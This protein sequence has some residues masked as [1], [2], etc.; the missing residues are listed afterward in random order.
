MRTNGITISEPKFSEFQEIWF[1]VVCNGNNGSLSFAEEV[2]GA[3]KE[4]CLK[5]ANELVCRVFE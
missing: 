2:T 4:D 1:S 5:A 3:T